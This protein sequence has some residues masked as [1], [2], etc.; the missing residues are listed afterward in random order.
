M[1]NLAKKEKV[2]D[3]SKYNIIDALKKVSEYSLSNFLEYDNKVI[4]IE[5]K[6][7]ETKKLVSNLKLKNTILS[8]KHR[9]LRKVIGIE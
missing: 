8:V 5:L 4:R 1:M 2:I 6:D 3:L 7:E 9:E